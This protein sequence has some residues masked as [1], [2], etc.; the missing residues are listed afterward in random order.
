MTMAHE[1]TRSLRWAFE[2]LKEVSD[3]ALVSEIERDR[4]SQLLVNYPSPTTVLAWIESD[5]SCI[6]IDASIAIEDAGDLLRHIS[7][8]EACSAELRRSV[9]FTLRHFPDSG[10][11]ESWAKSSEGWTIKTWLLPEN[12]YDQR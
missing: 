5:A 11:A 7:R 8:S 1:R 10:S 9:N 6:P 12:Q 3:D 2:V 4:A